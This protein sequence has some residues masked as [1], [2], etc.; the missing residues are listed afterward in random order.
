[1][2]LKLAQPRRKQIRRKQL[3]RCK[4]SVPEMQRNDG[5]RRS[6]E[7][8]SCGRKTHATQILAQPA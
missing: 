6:A 3:C 7:G 2:E 5:C 1:M 4:L 8:K